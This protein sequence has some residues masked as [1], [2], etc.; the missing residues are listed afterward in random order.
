MFN[1]ITHSLFRILIALY[2]P[3]LLITSF[4]IINYIYLTFGGWLFTQNKNF[5]SLSAIASLLG[6][7]ATTFAA[8]TA[9]ILVFN[10]K[11]Q[12]NLSLISKLITEIWDLHSQFSANFYKL[13][14]TFSNETTKQEFSELILE[15]IQI[16]VTLRSKIQQLQRGL[17]SKHI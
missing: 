15:L 9:A 1:K 5:D 4:I 8:I 13:T 2:I 14:Y 3:F 16:S 10:W 11:T 17:G 12:H 6:A 7:A